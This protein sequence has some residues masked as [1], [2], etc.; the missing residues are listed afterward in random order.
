MGTTA[1]VTGPNLPGLCQNALLKAG[2]IPGQKEPSSR[3]AS[4]RMVFIEWLAGPVEQGSSPGR[5][6]HLHF[7]PEEPIILS[8]HFNVLQ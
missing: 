1:E 5:S 7:P 8:I 3:P 2:M 6:G 4:A